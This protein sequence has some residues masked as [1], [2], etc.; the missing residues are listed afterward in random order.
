MAEEAARKQRVMLERQE[1]EKFEKEMK[2]AKQIYFL[3]RWRKIVAARE[4]KRKYVKSFDLLDVDKIG[5]PD[6]AAA[7]SAAPEEDEKAALEREIDAVHLQFMEQFALEKGELSWDELWKG[8]GVCEDG[9][10]PALFKLGVVFA[11][12]GGEYGNAVRKFVLGRL[13]ARWAGRSG[14][15]NERVEVRVVE[16]RRKEDAQGAGGVLFVGAK[17]GGEFDYDHLEHAQGIPRILLCMG[18]ILA[19]AV[20]DVVGA[21]NAGNA[22]AVVLVDNLSDDLEIEHKLGG[23]VRGLVGGRIPGID[24]RLTRICREELVRKCIREVLFWEDTRVEGE[25]LLRSIIR[26]LRAVEKVLTDQF[27]KD[28]R[29]AQSALSNLA[30]NILT[31]TP[32]AATWRPGPTTASTTRDLGR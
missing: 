9:G 18:W 19:T 8:D 7:R 14:S 27:A 5:K 20:S 32:T 12:D 15:T 1:R 13:G 22:N 30:A 26:G 4:N 6:A 16:V 17:G 2:Q 21:E 31:N 10:V 29:W 28:E 11:K 3:R 25:E 24:F 23:C